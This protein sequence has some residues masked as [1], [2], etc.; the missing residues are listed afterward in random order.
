MVLLLEPLASLS[1]RRRHF[2]NTAAASAGVSRPV[3][4]GMASSVAC[5][6][7][8]RQCRRHGSRCGGGR[9]RGGVRPLLVAGAVAPGH[10][11]TLQRQG[12][13]FPLKAQ[14]LQLSL[15]VVTG[16]DG[17]CTHSA[18]SPRSRHLCRCICIHWCPIELAV[19]IRLLG[20]IEL[21]GRFRSQGF[22]GAATEEFGLGIKFALKLVKKKMCKL[23]VK[24]MLINIH[25]LGKN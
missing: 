9:R 7:A 23:F 19:I 1:S 5:T 25:D 17:R 13:D 3:S 11:A 16:G 22:Y 18:G 2:D 6:S 15:L 24:N 8:S 4:G 10:I 21:L 14:L 20:C 12:V